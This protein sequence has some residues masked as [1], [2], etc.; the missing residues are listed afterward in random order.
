MLLSS[1]IVSFA[2]KHHATSA[3]VEQYAFTSR[4]SHAH[5]LG[6]LGGVVKVLLTARCGIPVEAVPPASA[7]KLILGRLP[8]KDVKVA[9]AAALT[10]MGMPGD[11]TADEADAFVCA[12]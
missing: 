8:R 1:E 12:N 11:W 10:R 3:V 7:R 6:E 2:E 4:H 5:S 9:T